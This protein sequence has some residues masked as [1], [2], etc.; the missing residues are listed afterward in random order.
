MTGDKIIK[1]VECC[2]DMSCSDCPLCGNEHCCDILSNETIAYIEKLKAKIEKLNKF[3]SYFDGLYGYGLEVLNWHLNEELE[4]FDNFYDSAI[5]EME[6]KNN[7][8]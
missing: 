1:A 8:V 6:S 5:Q 4:P 2:G 7:E 3:K